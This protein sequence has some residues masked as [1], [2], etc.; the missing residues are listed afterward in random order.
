MVAAAFLFHLCPAGE[1]GYIFAPFERRGMLLLQGNLV[2]K[3]WKG[4][5]NV[6]LNPCPGG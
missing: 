1:W 2:M 6:A 3:G 5:L 4:E